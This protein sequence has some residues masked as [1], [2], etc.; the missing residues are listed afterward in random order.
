MFNPFFQIHHF[1]SLSV[2][3]QVGTQRWPKNRTRGELRRLF[4]GEDSAESEKTRKKHKDQPAD[5]L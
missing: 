3:E 4:F 2:F 1:H 5:F